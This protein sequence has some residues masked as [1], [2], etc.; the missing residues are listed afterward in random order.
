NDVRIEQMQLGDEAPS[1]LLEANADDRL[2][3][4]YD[5]DPFTVYIT[6]SRDFAS[7]RCYVSLEG[8][9]AARLTRS[10]LCFMNQNGAVELKM[11]QDDGTTVTLISLDGEEEAVILDEVEQVGARV[12]Y[13]EALTQFAYTVVDG[14]E[15]Q[16]FLIEPGAEEGEL[17]GN[18]F[19]VIDSF[20]FLGDG[21]TVYV[22]GKLD[23]ADDELGLF[24]NGTGEAL[25]EADDLRF[26]SQSESG[27]YAVFLAQSGNDEIAFTYSLDD[28][29]VTELLEGP[30]ISWE[31]AA[32]ADFSLLKLEDDDESAL[33][34]VR[35]DGRE[36]VELLA[37]DAYDILS[38]YLNVAAEQLLVQLRDADNNDAIYVTSLDA[39]DGYFL[40]EKWHS[41][42]ILNASAEQF[43]FWGREEAGDDVALFSIPWAEDAA[44]VTLDDNADFGYY[45]AFFAGNGRSLYYTAIDNGFGDFELRTV[46]V[47]G[48]E[49]PNRLYR[50]VVLLDVRWEDE[51]NLQMV[52]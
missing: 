44:V 19:A 11:D 6:E 5:A 31:G 36:V 20:G 14:N 32:T 47:D 7:F 39:E 18:E 4:S 51:P 25:I 2:F 46:P 8:A 37:T 43:V 10:E 42:T 15:A 24:I 35:A 23:E 29:V 33:Y 34:S 41:L 17:V 16:L 22:I 50:D 13:N 9:R 48:S 28:N 12:R 45:N 40:L 1:E 38:L 27:D 3:A 21:E 30:A 52:R 49:R 26:I